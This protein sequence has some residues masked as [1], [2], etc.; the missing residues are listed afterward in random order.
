MHT[1]NPHH[2]Q[3]PP[4]FWGVPA[5]TTVFLS[6]TLC[7]LLLMMISSLHVPAPRE[8]AAVLLFRL[9]GVVALLSP[10][11]AL[12]A[13]GTMIWRSNITVGKRV[14]GLVLTVLAMSFQLE[15]LLVIIVSAVTVAI[16]PAQ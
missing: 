12:L 2:S 9:L 6:P 15:I 7:F 10:V 5:W 8:G 1:V 11:L 14:G 13:C 16:A 4:H 3:S